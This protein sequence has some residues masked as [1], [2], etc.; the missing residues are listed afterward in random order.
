MKKTVIKRRK[1]VPAAPGSSSPTHP[2]TSHPTSA[3]RIVMSDQ[4]AA[5]VLASVGR[6]P[7]RPGS[8]GSG[9]SIGAG[10]AG[11][12][13]STSMVQQG[14]RGDDGTESDEETREERPRRKRAK[15]GRVGGK[16]GDEMDVD[17]P[18]ERSPSVSV[19]G[20][21]RRTTRGGRRGS[22]PSSQPPVSHAPVP[23]QMMGAGGGQGQWPEVPVSLAMT[24]QMAAASHND[25]S[26]LMS[27]H[28]PRPGS[29]FSHHHHTH[30]HPDASNYGMGVGAPRGNPFAPTPHHQ[31]GFDLPSMSENQTLRDLMSVV[32]GGTAGGYG[33]GGPGPF[34]PPS[35]GHSPLANPPL[36]AYGLPTSTTHN[37]GLPGS[38]YTGRGGVPT[39]AELEMHYARLEEEKRRFEGMVEKTERLMSD[40]RMGLEEMK[41]G[42]GGTIGSTG[43]G[44][45]SHT[46]QQESP[47]QSP[48]QRQAQVQPQTS[49]TVQSSSSGAGT[50]SVP[51]QRVERTGSKES[52]WPVGVPASGSG[53]ASATAAG[54]PESSTRD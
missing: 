53:S 49:S 47:L 40:V 45:P 48:V 9:R 27:G 10:G 3:E 52:V 23:Q 28:P 4:A 35:R 5:E 41:R 42:G 20:R 7:P 2:S 8:A 15:K 32:T 31:G 22:N 24:L 30:G 6:A 50:T 19:R 16:D 44:S 13:G 18:D 43:S 37:S 34:L 33:R 26:S 36:N 46:M 17:E 54:A 29:A 21:G 51:I 12:G 14:G 1:R 25:G 38:S 11:A 39:V